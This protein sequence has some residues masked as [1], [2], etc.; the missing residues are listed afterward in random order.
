MPSLAL[1]A[2]KISAARGYGLLVVSAIAF[3]L[4]GFFTREAPVEGW[5]LVFWRNLF[6]SAALA[7]ILAARPNGWRGLA[8]LGRAGWATVIV[9]ALSTIC[10]LV[11]LTRT[12]VANVAI[13]YATAPLWGALIAWV[14]LG[15][16]PS[17][18]TMIAAGVALAGV[19]M[20]ALGAPP[21][22]GHVGDALALAMTIGYAATSVLARREPDMPTMPVSG[23]AA[24]L[25]AAA[26]LGCGALSGTSFALSGAQ[27]AWLAAFG[28]VTMGLAFPLFLAG[29]AVVPAGRTL[30]ISALETPLGPLWVWL[31]FGETPAPASLVGGAVVAAAILWEMAA[32]LRKR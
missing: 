9:M 10:Y 29:A 8:S 30:L 25:A 14:W 5:S 18:R 23:L 11:A 17:R 1:P 16:K 32:L 20:T 22:G 13:I 31:A 24:I 4:A 21:G 6:G 3:S 26:A 19:S 7:A 15:E 12:S 27:A 2:A 28:V